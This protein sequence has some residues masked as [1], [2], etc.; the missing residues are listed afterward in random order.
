MTDLVP[1]GDRGYLARFENEDLAARWAAAV[2]ARDLPG[3]VDVVPAYRT[4][5]VLADPDCVDLDDLADRLG[6][7]EPA[8][9]SDRAG[10]PIRIP[11]LYDGEDLDEVARRLE[12]ER[13]GGRRVALGGGIPRLRDRVS[14]GISV[15]RL[16]PG[17][18]GRLAA[19]LVTPDASGRGLGRD[20][21]KA[22]GRLSVD[23]ARRLAPARALRSRSSTCRLGIFRSARA[24]V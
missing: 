20:R 18:A 24:T 3:V 16:P 8:D 10:R 23:L 22:D 15:R 1:L 9:A 4:V 2:A 12:P 6:R 5:G 11:V 19:A 17:T 7:L 13:R 14:T 21:G